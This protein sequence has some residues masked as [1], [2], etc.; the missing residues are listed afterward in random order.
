MVLAI[1]ALGSADAEF[2][3][4][5]FKIKVVLDEVWMLLYKMMKFIWGKKRAKHGKVITA[6]SECIE[7][8]KMGF[9]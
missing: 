2:A 5:V 8:T 1:A 3:W 6:V 9:F 7:V 4:M